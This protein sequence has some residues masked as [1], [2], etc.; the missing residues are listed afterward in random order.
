MHSNRLGGGRPGMG[1]LRHLAHPASRF[2]ARAAILALVL[3]VAACSGSNAPA[4]GNTD[5]SGTPASGGSSTNAKGTFKP[6]GDMKEGRS[7]H[8]AVRL[9]EGRVLSAGGK[10]TASGQLGAMSDSAEVYDPATGLWDWTGTMGHA[11]GSFTLGLLPDGRVFAAGG[12]GSGRE[13]VRDA[14]VWDPA[15]G[16]WTAVAPLHEA[17]DEYSLVLLADGRVMLSGGEGGTYIPLSSVEIYDPEADTWE[18]AAPM[19]VARIFH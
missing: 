12:L 13:A 4:S 8:S 14:E 2:F 6:T 10:K 9:Q 17:R 7:F 3:A 19:S 1:I 11:R 16:Q 5:G 15:T 18:L